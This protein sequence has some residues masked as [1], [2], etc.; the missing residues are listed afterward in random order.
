MHTRRQNLVRMTRKKTGQS[1]VPD[2]SAMVYK[3]SIRAVNSGLVK[4]DIVAT[5]SFAQF[6]GG[7]AVGLQNYQ[8]ASNI[9]SCSDWSSFAT[10]FDE[11]RILGFELDWIPSTDAGN[12][13]VV[14]SAGLA[15][16][17]HSPANPFPFTAISTMAAYADWKPFNTGKPLRLEWKMQSSEEAQFVTTSTTINQGFIGFW[18]PYA[19][20]TASNSYG[21]LVVTYKVQFRGRK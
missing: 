17:T 1:K 13:S 11:Y 10:T 3:G 20:T 19:T 12:A 6:S 14:H 7:S 5:M 21:M 15:I 18:A 16:T 4:D 9:T 2:A 8:S